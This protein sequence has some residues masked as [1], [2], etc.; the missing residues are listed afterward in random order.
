KEK[1]RI[2]RVVVASFSRFSRQDV[3]GGMALYKVF[4][5]MGIEIWSV[6]DNRGSMADDGLLL[7]VEQFRSHRYLEDIARR[8]VPAVARRVSEGGW[9]GGRAPYAL[10]RALVNAQGKVVRILQPGERVNLRGHHVA[11]VLG[12][13]HEQEV[14]RNIFR[15][16]VQERASLRDIA[17]RLNACGVPS[18]LGGKWKVGTIRTILTQPA[19][20]GQICYNR[21]RMSK[22]FCLQKGQVVRRTDRG[23]RINPKSDWIVC[24]DAVPAMIPRDLWEKAQVQLAARRKPAAAARKKSRYLLSGIVHCGHCGSPMYGEANTR[25]KDGRYRYRLYVCSTAR[26]CGD[27]VCQRNPV[28]ADVIEAFVLKVLKDIYRTHY[29]KQTLLKKLRQLLEQRGNEP[30]RQI[31]MLERRIKSI[32]KQMENLLDLLNDEVAADIVKR[33][34]RDLEGTR[35]QLLAEVASLK[36]KSGQEDPERIA[37]EIIEKFD[38]LLNK[39]ASERV[40]KL[41]E[42][43]KC[44][45]PELR[46]YFRRM[47]VGKRK[48]VFLER[49][50][51]VVCLPE[52][53]IPQFTKA[54][55]SGPPRL[56]CGTNPYP[57][58]TTPSAAIPS[59]PAHPPTP[60]SPLCA[61]VTPRST[62]PRPQAS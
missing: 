22:Y 20:A 3:V 48:R 46:L 10:R 30:E 35:Q 16:F 54:V 41:R 60:K 52:A 2:S 50:E 12:P 31:A 25:L 62:P 36:A 18:P 51:M 28:R 40:T 55:N 34:M 42:I 23:V 17:N 43:I 27:A 53:V 14:V 39:A 5:D 1:E 57:H 56:A 11:L 26:S 59:P 4:H 37:S 24:K 44:F 58:P 15:W 21:R 45:V 9:C 6:L 61:S 13:E 32:E 47:K 8:A 7:A 49:G 38:V 19:Y 33:K 29:G